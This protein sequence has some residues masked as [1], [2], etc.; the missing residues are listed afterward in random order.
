MKGVTISARSL[1]KAR[2]LWSVEDSLQ[3]SSSKTNPTSPAGSATAEVRRSP[4]HNNVQLQP[5]DSSNYKENIKSYTTSG[6]LIQE[7]CNEVGNSSDYQSRLAAQEN[8]G[9]EP[10]HAQMNPQPT[11]FTVQQQAAISDFMMKDLDIA[12]TI[13]N[14]TPRFSEF[15][16]SNSFQSMMQQQAIKISN[17]SLAKLDHESI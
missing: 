14:L 8:E 9:S 3:C 2:I 10:T 16:I 17:P 5:K 7:S 15:S 6:K 13:L 11:P 4:M 1:E 12:A